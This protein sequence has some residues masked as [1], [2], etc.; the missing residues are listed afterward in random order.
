VLTCLT[1]AHFAGVNSNPI[2]YPSAAKADAAQD[3]VDRDELLAACAA[4]CAGVVGYLVGLAEVLGIQE[5]A[6]RRQIVLDGICLN[7]QESLQD[8]IND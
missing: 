3:L 6:L 5:K 4:E 7:R 8:Q 1:P 2:S